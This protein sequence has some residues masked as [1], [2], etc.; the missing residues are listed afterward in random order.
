MKGIREVII[1]LAAAL[2]LL[3][4]ACAPAAPAP[5]PTAPPAATKA[6]A[7]A[8]TATPA[9]KKLGKLRYGAVQPGFQVA[10]FDMDVEKGFLKEEGFEEVEVTQ[11]V[12]SD[13]NKA[14]LAG[15]LDVAILSP[16]LSFPAI[17]QGGDIP[18][19]GNMLY[20]RDLLFVKKEINS[21]KELEGR[22]VASHT[23]G[24]LTDQ[25]IRAIL[26]KYGVDINK[27]KI[28]QVGTDSARMAALLAGQA[29]ATV[30]GVDN[31]TVIEKN[32]NFKFLLAVR[33]ELP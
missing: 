6:P 10:Y 12:S 14:L 8:A 33:Q 27:V 1:V 29:D 30:G 20:P 32:P 21:V 25:T 19:I 31:L 4:V 18:M 17:E 24:S 28:V 7:A 23:P 16:G 13:L 5:T 22:T 11:A 15:Q 26:V 9:P 3:V 2:A